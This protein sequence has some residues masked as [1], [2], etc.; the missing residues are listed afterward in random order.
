[1]DKPELNQDK[2]QGQAGNKPKNKLIDPFG[3]RI[4]YVR[5]SVTDRC[6]LRCFYCL[7]KDFKEFEYSDSWLNFEEITRII[8]AF[9]RLGVGKVRIT[10]GE[11]LVRKD[12]PKLVG[13]ISA[14][15]GVTDL[16][17]STNAVL[18]D[19]QADAL[20]RS[21]ISRLNVS[22]DSLQPERFK[23]I[24][25]G[26]KLDKVMLGLMAAKAAGFSPIKINMVALKGVNDD[27]YEDMV[28]FC[29][30]HGFILRFIEIMPVGGTGRK[31]TDDF[32]NLQLLKKRLQKQYNLV[33]SL[34]SEKGPAR[35]MEVTGKN[36]QIGFISPMSQHFCKSC[37]RVRLNGE[38]KLLLCLG[39]KDSF[40]LRPLVKQGASDHELESAIR[41]GISL[42]PERHDF[43]ES[44]EKILRFMSVTGG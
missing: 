41:H 35:Y 34:V 29:V 1:M 40:D 14:L 8:A 10:G 20:K 30:K 17:L 31:A 38:G 4:D 18:L 9:S 16:S 37:N 2:G 5:L 19:K 25:K 33:P 43:N 39:Q 12:L 23:E 6:N 11:P 36:S 22:L 32:E 7:P 13:M 24:T 27:E 21:G 42:K 3:R 26:G 44:P 15:P 28:D